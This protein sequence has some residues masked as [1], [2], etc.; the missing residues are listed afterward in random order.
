M[1]LTGNRR[2]VGF[3]VRRPLMLWGVK[4]EIGEYVPIEE[5]E[6]IVRLEAMVRAGRFNAVYE[7]G[8]YRVERKRGGMAVVERT[9]IPSENV[10]VEFAGDFSDYPE[11]G[12]IREVK[13]WI[14]DDTSRAE[15]A[16]E[17]ESAKDN[18]RVTLLEWLMDVLEEPEEE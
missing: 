9:P 1:A 5:V 16:Y 12:T 3:V 2:P 18:P 6:S 14:G 11:D 15:H 7:E 17:R 10:P 13:E 8:D 4:R